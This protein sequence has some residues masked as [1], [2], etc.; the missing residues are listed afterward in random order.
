MN[1]NSP[2]FLDWQDYE[3]ILQNVPIDTIKRM[4]G[5]RITYIP[6]LLVILLSAV[7]IYFDQQLPEGYVYYEDVNFQ[8]SIAY[9]NEQ[10][11]TGTV[12][13]YDNH[14]ITAIDSYFDGQLHG[15]CRAWYPNG[16]LF[17]EKVYSAGKLTLCMYWD[18]NGRLISSRCW[19]EDGCEIIITLPTDWEPAVI[20]FE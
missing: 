4:M 17:F 13:Y 8:E 11:F 6:V 1:I 18:E 15:T 12:V 5:M 19:D 20:E 7:G 3:S 14:R 16:Q 2:H 10:P 9:L